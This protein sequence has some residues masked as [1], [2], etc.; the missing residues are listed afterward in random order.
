MNEKDENNGRYKLICVI[1]NY[2]NAPYIMK[3]GN[4]SD[5]DKYIYDKKIKNDDDLY[6]E[7]TNTHF[8]GTGTYEFN[9]IYNYKG[10][11]KLPILY[12]DDIL[13]IN[14][15]YDAVDDIMTQ[16]FT[17][18][19]FYDLFMKNS[20]IP[21]SNMKR[22]NKLKNYAKDLCSNPKDKKCFE[23]FLYSY[24]S[25]LE[26]GKTPDISMTPSEIYEYQSP[27]Y[28]V[29]YTKLR[30]VYASMKFCNKKYK[31][32]I[33]EDEIIYKYDKNLK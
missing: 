21:I 13:K 1:N 18:K 27:K 10:K 19:N 15:V 31:H 16:F 25:K 6:D 30:S 12:Y 11:R 9:I 8:E 20:V 17:D 22:D 5:I 14:N 7:L 32:S 2:T 23:R 24:I 4:I 33:I 28:I 3:S 26:P 29:Y